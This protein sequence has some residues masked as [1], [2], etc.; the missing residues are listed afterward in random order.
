MGE[1][2]LKGGCTYWVWGFCRG[3]G[4][5]AELD[6]Q[7]WCPT[8][9]PPSRLSPVSVCHVTLN[10]IYYTTSCVENIDAQQV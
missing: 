3:C 4:G 1:P 7:P 2:L 10:A 6:F 9:V 8:D 5:W